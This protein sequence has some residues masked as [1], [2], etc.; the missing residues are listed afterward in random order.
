MGDIDLEKSEWK[1]TASKTKTEHLV[2]LAPQ[3]VMILRELHPIT[4]QDRHGFVFPGLRPGKIISDNTLNAALRTLGYDT[5][6]DV[7]GHGFRATARTLL[8]EE[9]GFDPP[10]IEHQLAHAVPDTLGRAYIAN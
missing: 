9:L 1:Y 4:G 3:A 6:E 2:P 5:R 10:V 8:A 7:T